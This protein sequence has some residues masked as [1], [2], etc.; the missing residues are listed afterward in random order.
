M[1]NTERT[2]RYFDE[3]AARLE[4][5]KK[6]L[7]SA[8]L[9]ATA[10]ALDGKLEGAVLD[11]GSGG[12]VDYSTD[13]IDKLVSLDISS[14]SLER[15]SAHEKIELV[16]GDARKLDLEDGRF[17]RVVILHTI[18]HLAGDSMAATRGNISDCFRESHRVLKRTGR[19]L[20][21]D[22]VCAPF[23]ESIERCLFQGFRAALDFIKRPMVFYPSLG[24]ITDALRDSGFNNIASAPLDTGNAYL[25]PF[26]SRIGIPFKYTP[27][28]HILIEGEK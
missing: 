27:L 3:N 7:Q 21:I 1:D 18:H 4:G 26:T 23:V 16:R 14:C 22:A 12:R 6:A 28:S 9:A 24:R 17:D 13:R 2:Q 5:T 15:S 25:C 11:I 19:I 8:I 10:A 20:I